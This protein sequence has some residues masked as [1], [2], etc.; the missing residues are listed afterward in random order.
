MSFSLGSVA[1]IVGGLGSLAGGIFGGGGEPDLTPEQQ[2][3][4]GLQMQQMGL[5]GSAI[6][7]YQG[8]YNNYY[9]PIE[10]FLAGNY[11]QNIQAARPYQ[12]GMMNYQLDR[13]NE[14]IGLAK[15]TNPLVDESKKS[16]IRRL[17][18]GEDVLGER[19]RNEASADVA[20][21]FANQY[22]QQNRRMQ[23]AGINPN[24]GA[25]S[26]W[27]N[28]FAQT[29]AL[30]EAGART[31]ATTQASDMTLQR[32][33]QAQNLYTNP[34]MLYNAGNITPGA[35]IS[36]LTSGA[37][38][39][40]GTNYGTSGGSSNSGIMGGLGGITSGLAGILKGTGGL[41]GQGWV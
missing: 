32:Q 30:G 2:A 15:D 37:G 38:S 21:S 3:A 31:R 24:S 7:R 39:G 22:D 1:G 27:Q 23:Q 26:N 8:L 14:L 13:G 40:L 35:T 20:S 28:T 16:L 19:M 18:E 6:D 41:L 10:E 36:S 29:Q 25:Y 33:Q 17:T 34:S 4:L 11:L 9:W 12:Q 5:L